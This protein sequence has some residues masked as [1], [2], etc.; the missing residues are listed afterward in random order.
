MLAVAV[1]VVSADR[2][3][4]GEEKNSGTDRPAGSNSRRKGN[5]A[6][7]PVLEFTSDQPAGGIGHVVSKLEF[8]LAGQ[9]AERKVNHHLAAAAS[10][11]MSPCLVLRLVFSLKNCFFALG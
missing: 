5:V 3:E 9:L 10:G 4:K 6:R 1:A 8:K 7:C 11:V 2:G